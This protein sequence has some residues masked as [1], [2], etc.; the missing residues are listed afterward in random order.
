MFNYQRREGLE[1]V[2]FYER[3]SWDIYCFWIICNRQNVGVIAITAENKS[4]YYYYVITDS[5]GM[6]YLYCRPRTELH[7]YNFLSSMK[8]FQSETRHIQ[9]V[10][11]LKSGPHAVL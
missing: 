7:L 1:V 8:M 10:E 4:H 11:S 6:S 2:G 9:D 5:N 3:A